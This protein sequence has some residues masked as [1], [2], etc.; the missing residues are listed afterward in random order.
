MSIVRAF[1]V[2][3]V[4]SALASRARADS[5]P[6][7]RLA[8]RVTEQGTRMPLGGAELVVL[9][10]QDRELAHASTGADGRFAIA[11][12]PDADGEFTVVLAASD[13]RPARV[14]ER[15]KARE[16]VQVDYALRRLSYAQYESSVRA[17][18]VREEVARVTLTG[19]E[20]VRIPGVRGDLLGAVLNLPG[21]ARSPFDEG[22]LII[23]GAE[24]YE[25]GAFLGG[26]AIPQAFHFGSA[27]STFN[28]YLLDHFELN[29]SNFSVRFGR[30]IGGV[31][32]LQP[33]AGRSDRIHG[34]VKI[35]ILEAHVIVEGPIGKGSFALALRRSYI[36]AFFDAL[37]PGKIAVA[38]RYYDYQGIFDYPVA[39]GHLRLLLFG[40]DDAL[41]LAS[42][43]N[44]DTSLLGAPT[45]RYWFHTLIASWQKRWRRTELEATLSTGPQHTA[46]SGGA[47]GAY[48]QDAVEI[49]ARL[50]L[51]RRIF[52]SL[53]VTGGFDL[54]SRYQW[55]SV[56]GPPPTTEDEV[57][58]PSI[59][60][61]SAPRRGFLA[62]PALYAQ[63]DWQILRRLVLVAGVRADW[64][65]A[66]SL[67]YLQPRLMTRFEVAR[68]TYLKLGAGLFYQP[69]QPLLIDPAI[70]NP[71]LR[72]EQAVHLVAG[73]ESRP[74]R[75]LPSLSLESN[76]FYKDLRNLPVSADG[77]T[78]RDGHAQPLVYS[79]EGVGRVYGADLFVRQDSPRWL[80][81]WISYTLSRSERLDH[82]GQAWRS[83]RFDQTHVLTVV[84]GYHLPWDIDIGARFRYAT[85]NPDTDLS[86]TAQATFDADANAYLP[87][88]GAL[89]ATRLSDFWQLDVRVDKRFVFRTW[90]L[91]VYLDFYNVTNQTNVE[92]WTYSY[93]YSR[94][95]PTNGLPLIP[96]FGVRGSF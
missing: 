16:R 52:S 64:F 1:M 46:T 89:F 7:V 87:H 33:R 3:A 5:P 30:L 71:M 67:T 96:S 26:I 4:F 57:L 40:S 68:S 61:R 17:R 82:P 59:P 36:D 75:R 34:D 79:D 32:D 94:R 43:G 20:V 77:S 39:G 84:L 62:S 47:G 55:L 51:R 19:D 48:S 49:D 23:R 63:A 42:N 14:R 41:D 95:I 83:F 37:V 70:G 69:Q 24:P 66:Q 13:H 45:Q 86:A 93:D 44:I 12:S 74:F 85:G 56:D 88:P 15:L 21:V 29:P 65:A 90:I 18:P 10:A 78:Q 28:S 8:G 54:Q 35:D 22:Q 73:V 80:Y 11:L 31:V 92:G 72:P 50:E 53:R 60:A 27:T 9:D 76:A 38:P 81:G 58:S 25:S 2:I 6:T 91:S